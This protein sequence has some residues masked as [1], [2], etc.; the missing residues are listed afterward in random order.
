MPAEKKSMRITTRWA[1][2]QD[3]KANYLSKSDQGSTLEKEERSMLRSKINENSKAGTS[4]V[5][6]ST[7]WFRLIYK[8]QRKA[9]NDKG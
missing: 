7:K 8:A 2:E 9:E 3:S 6:D 5:K 4:D 1:Q